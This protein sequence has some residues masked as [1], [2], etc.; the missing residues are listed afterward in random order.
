MSVPARKPIK[1]KPAHKFGSQRCEKDGIKFP[2]KLERNCYSVLK[3]LES[4]GVILFF[5]RQIPFDLPGGYIHRVDY[6]VFTKNSVIFIE[7]KGKD[8]TV[9][10]MKRTQVEDLYGVSIFLAFKPE[11]IYKI[12]EENQ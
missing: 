4:T 5:L 3:D 2:S 6:C 8:L 11:Q 12:I 7:A 1:Y 10:K 9:G